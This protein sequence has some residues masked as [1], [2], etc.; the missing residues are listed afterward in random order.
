[1]VHPTVMTHEGKRMSK[2]L[3]TG[4]DPMELTDRYGTDATRFGLVYQCGGAQDIRF[5]E[6]RLEMARNFCNKLWNASRFV[7]MNLA[8]ADGS[9]FN[10]QSSRLGDADNLQPGEAGLELSDRWI[11]SRL[12]RA[13]ESVTRGLESYAVDDAAQV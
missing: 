1:L 10:V 9:K 6:D 5:T 13:V 8:P 11:L 4:I 3:G 2:T 7:L 12:Q